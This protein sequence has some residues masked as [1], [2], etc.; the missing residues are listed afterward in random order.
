MRRSHQR[1]AVPNV[2]LCKCGEPTLPHSIC[3][4]CGSYR[5]RQ[6]NPAQNAES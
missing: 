2:V 1:T 4:S 5:G 6:L 3:P